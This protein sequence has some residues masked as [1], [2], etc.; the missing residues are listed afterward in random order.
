VLILGKALGVGILSAALKKGELSAAGY[1]EMIDTTTRLN[2]PG[3][4]L[5]EM[6]GVH[7]LTDVTGFGLAGH[8]LEICRGSGLSAEID[9][10]RLPLLPH[11]AELARNGFVT[12][13]SERNWLGYGEELS[14]PDGFPAWKINILTDPQTSGGLL[15]ACSEETSRAA[16]VLFK[17]QGFDA[18]R[19]IGRMKPGAGRLEVR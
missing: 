15:L 4:Q 19:V 6:A 12:G 17:E 11:A 3:S 16:L 18:A 7:A 9:F 2:L 14:V 1:R 13:A 8:L 10:D 5:S